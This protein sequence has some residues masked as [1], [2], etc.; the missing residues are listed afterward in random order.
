MNESD[1]INDKIKFSYPENWKIIKDD[2]EEV[3]LRNVDSFSKITISI[4]E[5]DN[6]SIYPVKKD[7]EDYIIE[8]NEKIISSTIEP[9]GNTSSLNIITSSMYKNV[10]FSKHIIYFIKV[11]YSCTVTLETLAEKTEE[12]ENDL[13]FISNSI[14]INQKK[15]ENLDEILKYSEET[16]KIEVKDLEAIS[17]PENPK[18]AE[19]PVN[20]Q[21]GGDDSD[22][23]WKSCYSSICIVFFIIM[24]L[25]YVFSLI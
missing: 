25:M 6:L 19:K 10:E 16:N 23:D 8:N 12:F 20:P 1:F 17:S 4:A 15:E 14:K 21:P 7:L 9:I 22:F 5:T 11:D 3:I 24:F 13:I 2:T 18:P